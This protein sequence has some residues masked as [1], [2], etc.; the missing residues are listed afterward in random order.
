MKTKLSITVYAVRLHVTPE[1]L[2]QEVFNAGAEVSEGVFLPSEE[3][4][5]F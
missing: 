5:S 4:L 2:P 1:S 3:R